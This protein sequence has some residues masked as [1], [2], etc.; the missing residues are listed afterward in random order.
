MFM[1]QRFRS[2][3]FVSVLAVFSFFF[4]EGCM[5]RSISSSVGSGMG[6]P[7]QSGIARLRFSPGNID[8]NLRP[9]IDFYGLYRLENKD[10]VPST[11]FGFLFDF[12]EIND[13][14]FP[15]FGSSLNLI[16]LYNKEQKKWDVNGEFLIMIYVENVLSENFSIFYEFPVNA[17][18]SGYVFPKFSFIF[19]GIFY[20]KRRGR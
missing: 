7:P 6:F 4:F 14:I 9:T 2:F 19:G 13:K 11:G 20:I 17:L 5:K 15:A 10:I 1:I 18:R 16:Y 12:P 3:I 8:E